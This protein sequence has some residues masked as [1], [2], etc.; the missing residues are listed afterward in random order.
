MKFHHIGYATKNIEKSKM[1][2]L[3]LGYRD[4][5]DLFIDLQQGIRGIFLHSPDGPRIELVEQLEGFNV[6]EP[7]LSG[8]S[9]MYHLAFEINN[10]EKNQFRQNEFYVTEEKK[11]TAFPNR[12]VQFSLNPDRFM[13]EFITEVK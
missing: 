9:P 4:E 12:C 1:N 2:F 11:A 6:L 13:I 10:E 7:W 3:K 8:G 5:S